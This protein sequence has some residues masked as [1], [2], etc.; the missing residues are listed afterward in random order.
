MF[1][2]NMLSPKGNAKPSSMFA[3]TNK[4]SASNNTLKSEDNYKDKSASW[5]VA[6]LE[7]SSLDEEES[8]HDLEQ[9]I[10]N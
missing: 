5:G 10:N 6:N 1:L 7:D 4:P 3:Q 2:A 8:S 9:E